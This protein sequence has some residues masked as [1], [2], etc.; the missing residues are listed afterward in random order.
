MRIV[1]TGGC[2]FLGRRV[3]MRLLDRGTAKGPVERLVLFDNAKPVLPLP[4]DGRLSVVT[5]DIADRDTVASLIAPGTDAVFHLAAIVSG[6]A[7]ADTDLGYRVNLDGTRAVLDACRALG[8]TPRVIFASSLAVYGGA[9]PPEVGEAT[10]PTPQ[11]SYGAQKAIGELLVNDYSRK[12]FVDGMA[13]RLPTVVVRPGLPNRAASTFASSII[14]EPLTGREAICPVSPD[15]I[16]ALASPRRVVAGLT[17]ALDL[18]P[19]AL[20][21]NRSLQLPGFSVA[22]GEMTE[23]LRRAGGKEAYRRIR[24]QPDRLI[25]AII[26]SWPQALAAPRAEAL[27]FGRDS[28]IDEVIQAFI[29]DDLPLQRRLAG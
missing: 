29:E 20:G 28:G 11:S 23:A 24:W 3:A 12:G 25:Q 4:E 17:Q 6:Q 7:E 21:A 9:L 14:R 5:G 27:G 19:G 10:A 18:P 26:S 16:M 13:L 22:V 8:T 1:I 15:T 2:G